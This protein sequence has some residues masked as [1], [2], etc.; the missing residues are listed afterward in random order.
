MLLLAGRVP[1]P[2]GLLSSRLLL[3][4]VVVVFGSGL[5]T[6]AFSAMRLRM[7]L[8]LFVGGDLLAAPTVVV[9]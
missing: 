3:V 9:F 1:F 4:V 7:I 5:C 8:F 2:V 6:V